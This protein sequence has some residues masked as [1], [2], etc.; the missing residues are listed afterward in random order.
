MNLFSKIF[1]LFRVSSDAD[2]SA[3]VSFKMAFSNVINFFLLVQSLALG[4]ASLIHE[5]AVLST[6]NMAF[7]LF[8]VSYFVFAYIVHNVDLVETLDRI[9][10]FVY[11]IV[12]FV[13]CG[14]MK[15]M[16]MQVVLYPFVALI[17]HGR[18]VGAA[19]A[20]VQLV[21]L[22][23]CYFVMAQ[24]LGPNAENFY[25][26]S[27]VVSFLL[28]QIL[29]IFV[30]YVAIRWL[31]TM[32]Y[33]KNREIN[34]VTTELDDKKELVRRLTFSVR[35][36]IDEIEEA[37][38]I[39]AHERLNPLQAE[40]VG[41]ICA[42]VSNAHAEVAA[43]MKADSKGI[44]VLAVENSK[45]DVYVLIS[46]ALKVFRTRD[47]NNNHEF[48]TSNDV[49][50]QLFGNSNLL[51]QV[52]LNI[53]DAIDSHVPLADN[54]AV[55]TIS[56]DDISE[57][58]VRLVFLTHVDCSL[59][60]DR[61]DLSSPDLRL[62]DYF[63][64]DM[65]KRLVEA[66]DGCFSMRITKSG[67]DVEFSLD[68]QKG[69]NVMGQDEKRDVAL[70]RTELDSLMPLEQ[71]R[72]LVVASDDIF[73]ARALDAVGSLVAV[74]LR[75]HDQVE[76]LKIFSDNIISVIIA[77]VHADVMEGAR[78]VNKLRNAES[79]VAPRVPVVAYVSD[80][81]DIPNSVYVSSWFDNVLFLPF[82]AEKTRATI[83]SYFS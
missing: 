65:T 31:S 47:P 41:L 57:K 66:D 9:A 81:E 38:D 75:A 35:K 44:P 64:L 78:L 25:T 17:L 77:D 83:C 30:Y 11:F 21:F 20:F 58:G 54:K 82:D 61:R 5:D 76:A 23:V 15:V 45:F 62:L 12:V 49:P 60:L 48:K 51:R 34:I 40:L 4:L 27:E 80:I 70:A 55:V 71:A 52:L 74:T 72:V 22:A 1:N 18:H 50:R 14:D 42:S 24:I 39:L 68:F 8:F 28:L 73:W 13:T 6:I 29:S 19:L 63:N 33:D 26:V 79:G 2:L 53:L 37:S 56:R 59:E 67:L 10:I 46:A 3:D 43:V 36:S 32:I 69:N 7:S 16:G